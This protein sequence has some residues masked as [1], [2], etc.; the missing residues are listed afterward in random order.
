MTPIT[1]QHYDNV[2]PILIAVDCIIFGVED[3]NLKL[4]TFKREV[5]PLA[6]EWSLIGAFVKQNEHV[7]DAAKRILLELTGI[8]N[9]YMEQLH[10]FGNVN[11]DP[12]GR[13]ISVAYWSLIK[14]DEFDREFK[15]QNHEAKWIGIDEV[16]SLILDHNNMVQQAV[17]NLQERAKFH[18]IGFELLPEEFTLP[19][20]LKVYEAIFGRS[21]DDRNFRK[22]I[23]KS[24]LLDRLPKKDKSTS[25]KGS[26]LYKFNHEQYEKLQDEG[27]NFG[28]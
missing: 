14:S 8:D 1:A 11:R 24:G 5:E 18:P 22:K 15:V 19:Q 28:F 13:V 3:N 6:G 10:C 7:D 25:K 12:G 17:R 26:Y 9:I 4:L 2:E 20:L 16:P 21:I 23:L 27:Y